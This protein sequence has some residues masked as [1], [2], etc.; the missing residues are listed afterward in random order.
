MEPEFIGQELDRVEGAERSSRMGA[1]INGKIPLGGPPGVNCSY[2]IFGER[3]IL[4][5]VLGGSRRPRVHSKE[6]LFMLKKNN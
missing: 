5:G 3:E 6:P 2:Y 1:L 4:A